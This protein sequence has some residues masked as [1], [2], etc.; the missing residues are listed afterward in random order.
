L[1]VRSKPS[2]DAED[3]CGIVKKGEVFT[4]VEKVSGG[5]YLLKS[6]LYITSSDKYIQYFEK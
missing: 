6:G 3:V 5:F 1:N 4:V 2:W